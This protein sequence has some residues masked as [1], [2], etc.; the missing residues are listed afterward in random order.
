V[1]R[2]A[3]ARGRRAL[4]GSSSTMEVIAMSGTLPPRGEAARPHAPLRRSRP[5]RCIVVSA[6]TETALQ[7]T[8]RRANEIASAKLHR[9][10]AAQLSAARASKKRRCSPRRAVQA[11]RTP[12][13]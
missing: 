5:A 10:V 6:L 1:S 12:L 3:L 7:L 13:A 8:R 9:V 11:N 4:H 2:P